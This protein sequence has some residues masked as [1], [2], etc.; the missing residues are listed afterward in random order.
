MVDSLKARRPQ[1]ILAEIRLLHIASKSVF[2]NEYS[3]R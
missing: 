3:T 1:N 2:S